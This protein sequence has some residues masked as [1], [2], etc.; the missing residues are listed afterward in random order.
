MKKTNDNH[1]YTLRLP[2]WLFENVCD[3]ADSLGVT[4]AS[5]IVRTLALHYGYGQGPMA[6]T[7]EVLQNECGRENL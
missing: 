5:V 6:V 2:K 1:R 3:E 4:R 7:Q